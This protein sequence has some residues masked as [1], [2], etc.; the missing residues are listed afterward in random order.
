MPLRNNINMHDPCGC[1][2]GVGM[3]G[4]IFT[5]VAGS[6]SLHNFLASALDSPVASPIIYDN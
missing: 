4:M 3:I 1:G 6:G 5:F 2:M